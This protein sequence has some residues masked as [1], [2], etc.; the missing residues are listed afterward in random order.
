MFMEFFEAPAF[1]RFLRG[2]LDD[3]GYRG[4]Q[5][6]LALNPEL[7]EVMPGTAVFAN[8][9]GRINAE[10]KGDEAGSGSFIT[11]FPLNSRSG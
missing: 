8:C 5:H 2:Y 7:G 11:T 9:G 1:T 6:L 10:E 3:E 4:L